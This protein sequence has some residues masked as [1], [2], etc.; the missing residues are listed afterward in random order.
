MPTNALE[1]N[2]KNREDSDLFR[3]NKTMS[4]ICDKTILFDKNV[5]NCNFNIGRHSCQ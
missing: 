3:G 5:R 1:E 2:A 4:H